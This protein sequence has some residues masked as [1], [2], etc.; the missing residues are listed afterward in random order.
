MEQPYRV[1]NDTIVIPSYQ[2]TPGGFGFLPVNAFLIQSQ[3][4]I[5]IDT[6]MAK[7]REEFMKTLWSL[8]DPKDLRWVFMTHED[9]DHAGNLQAVME[10]APDARLVTNFLGVSK[11]TAEWQVPLKRV[12]FINHGQSFSAGDRQLTSLRPPIYDSGA[13]HGLYDAK[14][15]ALYT[16]DAFGALIPGPA[17]DVGD[18][19]EVDFARGFNIFNQL[20]SPWTALVDHSKFDKA[21][22][23]IR[24]LQPTTI[25]S[26][27]LPAAHGRT[28]SLLKAMSGIPSIEPF[29]GPD[30]AALE[31]MLAQMEDGSSPS[32]L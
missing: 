18:V 27:H 29:V 12:L 5:L 14:T 15:G 10:A 3:E 22:E 20:T 28:D 17:E 16:A 21:L 30:Q 4:P 26:S 31:A 19:P 7:D 2:P 25:L 9:K 6:C 8:I 24:Q 11:L 23:S 32:R 1:T 13:T